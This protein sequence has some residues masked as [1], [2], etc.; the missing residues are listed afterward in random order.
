MERPHSLDQRRDCC[1]PD[2]P[3]G[4]EVV[5]APLRLL[6]NLIAFAMVAF[7]ITAPATAWDAH[8]ISH[9]SKPVAV[10]EHHHHDEDGMEVPHGHGE[11]APAHADE[12]DGGHDHLPS[13]SATLSAVMG[14]GPL[15]LFPDLLGL[16]PGSF[17]VKVPVDL[18]EPPPARPPRSI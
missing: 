15:A 16:A 13:L 3:L 10:D 9:I 14:S 2:P 6:R 11:G 12:G 8:E 18:I 4:L 17:T 1:L 7:G 5:V